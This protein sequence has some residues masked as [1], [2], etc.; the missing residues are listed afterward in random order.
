MTLDR[1]AWDANSRV[2]LVDLICLLDFCQILTEFQ[3]QQRR[4]GFVFGGIEP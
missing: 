3:L 1:S 4:S 2:S